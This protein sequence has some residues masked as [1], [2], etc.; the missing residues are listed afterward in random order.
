MNVV[1][2]RARGVFVG[3]GSNLDDPHARLRDALVAFDRIPETRL[4]RASRCYRTPPWGVVEQPDFLNMVV[5]LETGLPPQRLVTG[6]LELEQAAG[7]HR[8]PVRW[9]PRRLDLDLLI[10]GDSIIDVPGCRVPHP[11]LA[12]RAFVLVPLAEL[13]PDLAV[14]GM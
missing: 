12:E 9:G 6:L 2:T 13:A 5:E 11:R 8:G 3:L 4:L 1:S 14:P 7:R 10:Y